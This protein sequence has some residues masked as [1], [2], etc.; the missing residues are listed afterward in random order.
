MLSADMTFR[1]IHE[2]LTAFGGLRLTFDPGAA[3]KLGLIVTDTTPEGLW[4]AVY[5]ETKRHH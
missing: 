5:D 2:G 1:A 4:N 3:R